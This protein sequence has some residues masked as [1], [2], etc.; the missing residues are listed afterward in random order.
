MLDRAMPLIL[1]AVL[2]CLPRN[3]AFGQEAQNAVE[4]RPDPAPVAEERFAIH[5]QATYVEQSADGFYSPYVGT[6]SLTPSQSRETFDATL[7]LGARLWRGA[8]IWVTPE[9]DQGFGL[10]DTLGLAG[11]SSGEAYK[12]GA[13]Q[14][15]LRLPRAFIRQTINEGPATEIIEPDALQLGG[16]RSPDRWVITFGKFSVTDVFDTNQYAH[17]PRNDFLNW[18]VVDA[19][20]FDYAADAWG[21]T[22]GAAA[23]RY[24]GSWTL[25]AGFFDL[26]NVPNSPHLEPGFDEFQ[27]IGELEKRYEWLGQTGRVVINGWESRG[28]MGLLQD[29]I[30]LAQETG[31]VPDPALVRE[32]RSRFGGSVNFEQP[33][34]SDLGVFARLSKAQG[35]VEVYEFTD[36]D[37]SMSLGVSLKGERWHRPQ[38]VFGLAWVD[39]GISAIREQYLND[40]GLGILVGDGK[41][42]RPG[43][44]QIVETFYNAS[45]AP[46]AFVGLDYQYITNPAYN[47]QR[48]PVSI[49]AVR[50]HLQF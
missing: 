5:A 18:T 10:D 38:D 13:N 25:R 15:Y 45:L 48:G 7:Y 20:A 42:P 49:F 46:W 36:L 14:P 2:V 19:G 41:L 31:G 32:Y 50:V 21:F 44:E 3:E 40:G 47:T 17:D 22:V 27:L 16:A 37:R 23:E 35:N 29:A 30:S 6:N 1:A 12:V 33:I 11:F 43:A 9:I 8:E 28:R 39:N 4:V 26:S 34:R 24:F